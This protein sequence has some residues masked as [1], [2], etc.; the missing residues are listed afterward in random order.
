MPDDIL[1]A[2]QKAINDAAKGTVTTPV[3]NEAPVATTTTSLPPEPAPQ[4]IIPTPAASTETE[5]T[6][7]APP[8]LETKSEPSLETKTAM[9]NELLGSATVAPSNSSQDHVIAAPT[10]TQANF[11]HKEKPK[12]GMILAAIATL[13]LTLPV[14]VYY[15][16]LQNQQIADVRS[17]A[18]VGQSCSINT[19]DPN[20]GCPAG[21]GCSCPGGTNCHCAQNGGQ[22]NCYHTICP[23]NYHCVGSGESAYCAGNVNPTQPPGDNNTPIPTATTTVAPICQ[24]LKIY[25]GGVQVATSALSAGDDVVLAVKGNLTPTKAHFRI[26][27]GAWQESAVK[28]ASN[29]FTLSY[30]IPAG[31]PAFVIE[32]EVF[33]NAAW[34]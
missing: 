18:Y 6:P 34:Y 17:S 16:S 26:N 21:E 30:T 33:T 23:V 5:I 22:N 9:V 11:T 3:V 2:A 15:V 24:N 14:A 28:N 27:G 1:D 31:I 20:G 4:P 7:P 29:E 19:N 12:T 32:A 10:H 13:L 25:K 8:A